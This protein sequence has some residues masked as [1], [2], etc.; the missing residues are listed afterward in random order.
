MNATV[1][2]SSFSFLPSTV[3]KIGQTF[4]LCLFLVVSL[5][6]NSFT[7][8]VV[9]KRHTLRK[10]INYFIP[11]MAMSDL[12]YPIFLFPLKLN[13]VVRGILAYQWSR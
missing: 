8:I 13:M 6:G 9:C 12:L 7:G 2:G 4:S 3:R 10:P 11:N 1:N 5:V